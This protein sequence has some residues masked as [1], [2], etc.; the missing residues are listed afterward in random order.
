MIEKALKN[1][2]EQFAYEPKVENDAAL[3]KFNRFIVVGMGGSNLAS[4][5]L[6]IWQPD[7]SVIIHR[8]YGL[9]NV[10]KE[11]IKKSLIVLSSYSGNTEEVIDAFYE[12]GKKGLSRAVVAAG[13]KLLQ[14][15]KDEKLPYIELPDKNIQPRLALGFSFTA[16]AKLFGVD[17]KPLKKIA[18]DL[19]SSVYDEEGKGLALKFH[20]A[21]PVIYSSERNSGLAY[22]W[23]IVFNETGKIPAF[24]NVLPELNH[25]EMTGF[26]V[27]E[28]TKSLSEK[29]HFIFLK[30]ED[31]DS[32]I[33]KRMNVL[34][35]L[36][37]ERGLKIEIIELKGK[38]LLHKVF[39]S[40]L[41]AS[42]AAYHTA[43]NYEVEPEAVPMVEEFKKLI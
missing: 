25:N 35:K 14:S 2:P 18:D 16:L 20:N 28:S 38:S 43:K 8:N 10:P 11:D 1:F 27:V 32:K 40:Y 36:Y 42:W 30:D 23:K 26:D 19:N 6:K 22:A 34:E 9:P 17:I 4:G 29:F 37:L 33:T 31:D 7:L 3:G 24:Y 13:G 41:L 21:V 39:S 12:A 15:T 5:L